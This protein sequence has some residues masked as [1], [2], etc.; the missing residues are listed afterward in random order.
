MRMQTDSLVSLNELL[1]MRMQIDLMD[2]V[3]VMRMQTDL[4]VL[5]DEVLVVG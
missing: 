2:D 1:V 3:L 5:V 4:V